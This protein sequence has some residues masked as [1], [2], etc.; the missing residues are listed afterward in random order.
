MFNPIMLDRP[1]FLAFFSLARLVA[2]IAHQ[3]GYSE[4]V[5]L[6][7]D[8]QD[9][10]S[11]EHLIKEFEK[12]MRV[13]PPELAGLLHTLRWEDDKSAL[14]LQAADML[15]WHLRRYYFDLINDR[16]PLSG[17][18]NV[19]LANIF[20]LVRDAIEVWTNER[21]KAAADSLRTPRGHLC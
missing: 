8:R 19:Y 9:N 3:V 15:A 4:Q 10:E 11:K 6:L 1:Y 12:F 17:R 18:T 13:A 7:F 5:E 14:P 20:D 16:N 21:L 2:R